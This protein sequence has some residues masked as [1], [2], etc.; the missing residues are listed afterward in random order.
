MI[1]AGHRARTKIGY[2]NAAQIAT[3]ARKNGTTSRE[4]ALKS[5]LVS[6]ADYDAI[7][8]PERMIG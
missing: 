1:A 6:A 8:R 7:V 5:G 4:E 3:S 2:D